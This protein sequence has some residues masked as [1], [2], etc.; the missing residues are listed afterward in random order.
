MNLIQ[1]FR[2]R[3]RFCFLAFTFLIAGVLHATF[4][5]GQSSNYSD[6]GR[7]NTYTTMSVSGNSISA[8]SSYPTPDSSLTQVGY[9]IWGPTWSLSSDNYS[10]SGSGSS[11]TVGSLPSGNYI[12]YF[13]WYVEYYYYGYDYGGGLSCDLC[14]GYDSPTGWA[15]ITVP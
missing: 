1:R 13:Y 15:T 5:F 14:T 6:D 11:F 9:N 3:V 2:G 4:A 10:N 8:S 7:F 12:V